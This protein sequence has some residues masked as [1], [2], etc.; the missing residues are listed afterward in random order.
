MSI[1]SSAE[2]SDSFCRRLLTLIGSL[3]VPSATAFAKVLFAERPAP[4]PH[5]T[6]HE[7]RN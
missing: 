7:Y 4:G 5:G 1:P 6:N 3:L 2:R